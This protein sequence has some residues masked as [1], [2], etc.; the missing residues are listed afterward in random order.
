MKS[1]D[2]TKETAEA[3]VHPVSP[4]RPLVN[5]RRNELIFLLSNTLIYFAAPVTYVGV[6]QAGLCD[7]LGASATIA[8]LPSSVY[9]I[10]YLCPI[11]LSWLVP[12]SMDRTVVVVSYTL[13]AV[14]LIV[15]SAA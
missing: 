1:T 5:E 10:G 13:M 8:N 12:K 14:S 6:V 7:R 9:L 2:V 11:F 3:S 15:V 4:E